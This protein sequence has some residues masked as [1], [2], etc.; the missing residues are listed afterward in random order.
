MAKKFMIA[1]VRCLESRQV[2]VSVLLAHGLFAAAFVAL[3][4][5]APAPTS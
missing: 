3:V 2:C 5:V 4:A 1:K